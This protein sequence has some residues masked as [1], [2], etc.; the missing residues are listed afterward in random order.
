MVAN[1]AANKGWALI[2]PSW[3]ASRVLLL[4]DN[5]QAIVNPNLVYTMPCSDKN[6]KSCVLSL[7]TWSWYPT[8]TIRSNGQFPSHIKMFIT[9]RRRLQVQLLS[10]MVTTK[11]FWFPLS[12]HIVEFITHSTFIGFLISGNL[13]FSDFWKFSKISPIPGLSIVFWI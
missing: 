10:Q 13:Q 9:G 2:N 1:R 8:R 4:Q 12:N 6:M 3:N 5:R 7:C 11:F